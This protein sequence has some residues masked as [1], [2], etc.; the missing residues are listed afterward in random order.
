MDPQAM[1]YNNR[2]WRDAPTPFV[3]VKKG[4]IDLKRQSQGQTH[5]LLFRHFSF[6][7]FLLHRQ[8]AGLLCFSPQCR[9]LLGR[10]I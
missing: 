5:H 8:T 9:S 2:G 1:S 10:G 7:L 6:P 4:D 3:D